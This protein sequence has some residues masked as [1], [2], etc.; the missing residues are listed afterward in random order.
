M[1]CLRFLG[2]KWAGRSGRIGITGC[3]G[4]GLRVCPPAA[5]HSAA[6][7]GRL[8]YPRGPS[9]QLPAKSG[10]CMLVQEWT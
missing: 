1:G 10:Y 9:P 3:Q 7:S 8:R 4:R 2:V 6:R 5:P